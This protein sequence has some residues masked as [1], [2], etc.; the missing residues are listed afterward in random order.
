[1][2]QILKNARGGKWARTWQ[3]FCAGQE[4]G[5]QSGEN[6]AKGREVGF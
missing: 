4:L 5:P 2:A 6:L 3:D 1:M